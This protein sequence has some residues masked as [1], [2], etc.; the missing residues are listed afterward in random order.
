MQNEL[1]KQYVGVFEAWKIDLAL[2]RIKAMGFGRSD[3]PDLMQELAIVMLEFRYD[4]KKS[5]GATE[6][7]V[8]YEVINRNLLQQMRTRCRDAARLK[9]YASEMGVKADGTGE[10]PCCYLSAPV[11]M[12]VALICKGMSDFDQKVCRGI[13]AGKTR[14]EIARDLEC[15][16]GTVDNAIRRITKHFA[17]RGMKGWVGR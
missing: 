2:G 11:D 3:W 14:A 9:R 4:P 8:F 5:N 17:G 10:E 16:W 6:Q 15:D 7:T 13:S 12:D 1:K